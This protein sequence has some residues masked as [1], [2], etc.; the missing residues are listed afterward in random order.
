MPR[1]VGEGNFI[2]SF[3]RERTY[4]GYFVMLRFYVG[5]V[6]LL[7]GWNKYSGGWLNPAPGSSPLAKVLNTWFSGDKPMPPGWY[8]DLLSRM[9]L[10][11]A[12]LFGILVA[13]GE[14]AVGVLLLLG[15]ATR[16]GGLLAAVMTLNYFLATKHVG[17][18]Y[19]LENQLFILAGLLLML[20]AAGRAW[21]V[22]FFLRRALPKGLLW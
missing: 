3:Y 2:S 21:G 6:F 16:L 8:H 9:V 15:L 18:V 22:D 14:L 4:L 5:Y 11:N 20:S 13:L 19:V 17:V 1:K 10:P 7:A 12:H